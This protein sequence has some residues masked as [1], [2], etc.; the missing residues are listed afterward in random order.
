MKK[1][2]IFD[3]ALASSNVGDEIILDSVNK[4]M[5]DIFDENFCLRLATH[6]NN[7][8]AKQV[9]HSYVKQFLH[10]GTKIKYYQKADWKFICGTN[11]IAQERFAKINTQWKIYPSNLSIYK[12]CV[13]LG[14]GTVGSSEKFDLWGRYIYNKVLSKQYAHSVRDD[15]TKR[16]IE[17]LGRRAI[18][19]GC[20]S[21]WPLTPECCR[22]IPTR[23]A[24]NC[25][26]S[27][28]GYKP[29]TDPANDAKMI[30]IIRRNYRDVRV[31]IQT[32]EDESYLD[33]LPGGSELKRIYSLK[34]Y[35]EALREGNVDYVGTRLHGGVFA[36]QN[37]CR[38][39]IV[40]I[41]HRAEGFHR[42]NHLPILRREEIPERLESVIRSE[43]PT[44]IVLDADAIAEFKSQFSG[45]DI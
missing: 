8:S 34:R 40:S 12:N 17:S 45:S 23:K 31:W 4:S 38:S 21:L 29:Q 13:L 27:V 2:V 19:T 32:T 41:D 7:F 44:E 42:T 9:A 25:I 1:I 35:R 39:L 28:S 20:P 24:E 16:L 18:N 43:F 30:E 3:T 10:K 11:L 22:Q 5:S 6:V 15:L 37:G 33:R 36:M 14:V 26:L